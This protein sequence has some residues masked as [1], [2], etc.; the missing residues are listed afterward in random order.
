[1]TNYLVLVE[2]AIE[3]QGKFLII[4]R[5]ENVHAGGLLSFP[6]GKVEESDAVDDGSCVLENAVKREILEEVGLTLEDPLHYVTTAI[7]DF[8]DSK[9]MNHVFYCKLDKTIPNIKPSPR[10]V[11]EY[12]FMDFET[13]EKKENAPIWLKS[14][15]TKALEVASKDA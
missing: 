3:Y 10:E 11:P 15:F 9:V 8:R 12:Y 7:F 5:P 13:L 1:M 2:C 14:Y 4:K 6:G